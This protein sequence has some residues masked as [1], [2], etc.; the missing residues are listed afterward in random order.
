MIFLKYVLLVM[1]AFAG[2][3]LVAAGIFT[4]MTSLGIVTRLAQITRTA[5]HIHRY[6]NAVIIGALAGHILWMHQLKLH[7]KIPGLILFALFSGIYVG[8]LIGAIAEILDAFPIFFRRMKLKTG[9]AFVIAALALGKF[10]G[11]II[12]YI[13]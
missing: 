2:G 13:L 8:C 3:V 5:D 4:L 7:L 11:V 12:Q 10:F 1:A 9:A 6:E